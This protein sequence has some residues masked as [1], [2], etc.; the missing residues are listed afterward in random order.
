MRLFA[1][2]HRKGNTLV[3]V[4]HE[5]DIAMHA[6]RIIHIKDGEIESD[7]INPNPIY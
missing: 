2:I 5:H 1:E 6:H 4:T 3:M 7:E